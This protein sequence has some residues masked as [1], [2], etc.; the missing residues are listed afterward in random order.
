[1]LKNDIHVHSI[2]HDNEIYILVIQKKKKN[3]LQIPRQ[4]STT[5]NTNV[6]KNDWR[7]KK[8][9]VIHVPSSS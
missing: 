5:F 4:L 7:K 1:M 8:T 3:I 6:Y 2:A 9:K